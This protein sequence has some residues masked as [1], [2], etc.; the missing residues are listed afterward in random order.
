MSSSRKKTDSRKA[1]SRKADSKKSDSRKRAGSSRKDAAGSRKGKNKGTVDDSKRD[2]SKE[3]SSKLATNIDLPKAAEFETTVSAMKVFPTMYET[4]INDIKATFD[5]FLK[6]LKERKEACLKEAQEK[7]DKYKFEDVSSEP[8]RMDVAGI[9]GS[10]NRC[11]ASVGEGYY[12][13]ERQKLLVTDKLSELIACEEKLEFVNGDFMKTKSVKGIRSQIEKVKATLKATEPL[14]EEAKNAVK[15]ISSESL[16]EIRA[17]P[18]PNKL[19]VKAVKA[20]ALLIG[21]PEKNLTEWKH[22]RKL[23]DKSFRNSLMAFEGTNVDPKLVKMLE[24]DYLGRGNDDM[25]EE[26]KLI[27]E[28]VNKANAVAGSLV[29]WLEAQL[30]YNE[31]L[32]QVT[33]KK[34]EL[35]ELESQLGMADGS[36]SDL[37]NAIKILEKQIPQ[38]R[39]K[40]RKLAKKEAKM[41]EQYKEAVANETN[42]A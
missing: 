39:E 21:T 33:A 20:C 16:S 14:L 11:G 19:L 42:E 35:K 8:I 12:E 1:D 15:D 27:F 9:E 24:K 30:K 13:L 18:K 5:E 22:M 34:K 17:L 3:E 2:E 38:C 25:K 23:C 4:D 7:V 26:D 40:L 28:N 32:P 41:E 29:K 6:L 36:S 10:I 37:G 31:M